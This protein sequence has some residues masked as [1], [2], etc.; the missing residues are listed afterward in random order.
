MAKLA[1]G[2][3]TCSVDGC[4][5]V[6]DAPKGLCSEH[7]RRWRN[8]G[9]FEKLRRPK[10]RA[11]CSV[12]G[13]EERDDGALGMC[14]VHY[15]RHRHHGH[16]GLVREGG[17]RS[18]PLYSLWFDRKT[19]GYLADEWLD[20]RRFVSDI[21]PVPEEHSFLVRLDGGLPYGP[22]NFKWQ[23]HLKRRSGESKKDWHARKWAARVAANP[24]MNRTRDLKRRFGLSVEDYEA[25]QAAQDG[26]CAI[27]R[28]VETSV[29]PKTGTLKGLAVDHCH[30]TNRVRG[31]LCFRC[32]TTI[33]RVGEDIA[34]VDAIREYL[35]THTGAA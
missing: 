9:T 34:L 33:G 7:Y 16:T 28:G 10:G 14:R 24:S 35:V 32:N 8:Y 12:D 13:C 31:L 27:C 18:H 5:K 20:F 30:R 25:L 2:S 21:S 11:I 29:D 17:K 23:P 6:N 26:R 19:H 15:M 1:R 4:G 3:T 22:D